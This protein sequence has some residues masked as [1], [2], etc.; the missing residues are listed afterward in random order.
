MIALGI[1]FEWVSTYNGKV[2]FPL[3]NQLIIIQ[4][5][6]TEGHLIVNYST[7][8]AWGWCHA[9][10]V[11]PLMCYF[12]A[13]LFSSLATSTRILPCSI[14]SQSL[15]YHFKY[16]RLL[17]IHLPGLKLKF[18]WSLNRAHVIL[19]ILSLKPFFLLS[20]TWLACTFFFLDH[21]L[22]GRIGNRAKR[23]LVLGKVCSCKH[24]AETEGVQALQWC[25]HLQF[26]QRKLAL[27]AL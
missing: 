23:G 2:V 10:N 3:T 21:Q 26:R 12:R 18:E 11:I 19:A 8:A 24:L 6:G 5:F 25:R 9:I 13:T 27:Q 7:Q 17:G 22:L 15:T 14:V 4:C 20:K 16:P 1:Y